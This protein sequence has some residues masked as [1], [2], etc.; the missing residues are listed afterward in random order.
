[1]G[2]LE[3][4]KKKELREEHL[5]REYMLQRTNNVVVMLLQNLGWVKRHFL[6]LTRSFDDQK[7]TKKNFILK[8]LLV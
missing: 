2:E 5:N 4:D 1:M 7:D 3:I 8:K 6:Y